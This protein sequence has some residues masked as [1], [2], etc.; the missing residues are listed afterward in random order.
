MKAEHAR[1]DSRTAFALESGVGLGLQDLAATIEAR[2]ADV[3]AKMRFARGRLDGGARQGNGV[4]GAVHATLRGRLLVLLNGHK[5]LLGLRRQIPQHIR[6]QSRS[7]EEMAGLRHA[8]I[9]EDVLE[10]DRPGIAP[11]GKPLILA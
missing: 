2:G 3:V 9:P 5:I 4:V 1:E 8:H 6:Q 7:T 10:R 11:T